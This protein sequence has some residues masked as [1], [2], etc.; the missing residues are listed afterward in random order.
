[1]E[2]TDT[3]RWHTLRKHTITLLG[4]RS[5]GLQ[6]PFE[7][8][9]QTLS[10]LQTGAQ[11]AL[12]LAVEAE[13]TRAGPRPAWLEASTRFQLTGLGPG[14]VVLEVESPTLGEAAPE[15][16]EGT[17]VSRCDVDEEIPLD[18]GLSAVDLFGA[19]LAAALTKDRKELIADRPLLKTIAAFADLAG[20]GYEAIQISGVANSTGPIVARVVDLP[21]LRELHDGTPPVQAARV[22]GTLDTISASRRDAA[23]VLRS[24][25]RILVRLDSPDAD[26][27]RKLF[28]RRVVIS[29]L[30]HFR[31]SGRLLMIEAEHLAAAEPGSEAIWERVPLP[32]SQPSAPVAQLAG[33]DESSGVSA[34]FGIW[35]GPESDGELLD[36]LRTIR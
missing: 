7:A 8:L 28:S 18:Q 21:L 29:G 35:P 3:R 34:F 19:A 13:S 12:R 25:E 5:D 23:V 4:G 2:W 24:G 36:A 20:F 16:F 26:Q 15:R 6:V 30:A 11:Q 9:L 17:R 27:L 1:M 10:T 33:Q 14:S 22:A 32:R 31:P